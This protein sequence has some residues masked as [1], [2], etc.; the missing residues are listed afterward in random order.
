MKQIE[1]EMT[2]EEKKKLYRAIDYQENA[3]PATYPEEYVD[4]SLAFLLRSLEIELL[5]DQH[6]KFTRVMFTH[7]KGV[8]VK[9]ATRVAASALR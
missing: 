5:D 1:E 3:A 4:N 8:K 7:L 2:P 6:D 9:L